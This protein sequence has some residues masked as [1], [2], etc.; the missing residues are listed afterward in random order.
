[1][2]TIARGTCIDKNLLIVQLSYSG[3]EEADSQYILHALVTK[4]GMVIGDIKAKVVV[5]YWYFIRP[6]ML[7]FS[8]HQYLSTLGSIFQ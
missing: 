3:L 1:L 6:M 2:P 5:H 8:S 7:L 4:G